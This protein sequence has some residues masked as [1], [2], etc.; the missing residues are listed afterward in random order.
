VAHPTIRNRGTTVGSIAHADPSAEMPAVITLL[1]GRVVAQSTTG[2]RVIDAADFFVGPLES[3]LRSDELATAIEVP[4]AEPG[5]GTAVV[6]VARRHGDYAVCGVVARAHVDG[7]LVTSVRA[8]YVSAGETGT[9]VDLMEG[10]APSAPE[11]LDVD[12][13]ASRAREMVE[14]ETDIHASARYR[15]QLVQV[16]TRRAVQAAVADASR[17]AR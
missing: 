16:L 6:E 3:S 2:E 10:A 8:T 13:L 5:D 12:G 7:G 14:T 11:D 15:S 4:A 9:V 1:G 17:E